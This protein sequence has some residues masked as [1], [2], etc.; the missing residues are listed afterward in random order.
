MKTHALVLAGLLL[1]SPAA[2][3]TVLTGSV[4]APDG[5]EIHYEAAGNGEPALVFVHCWSC[6]RS[7]WSGQAAH[8]AKSRRTV[9]I[10]LAGHGESGRERQRYTVE[11]FGADVKALVDALGLKRVV[12]V[13]H[14]MGGPVILE[15]AR[16]MPEKVAALVPIDTLHRV[17]QKT[18]PEERRAL[19]DPMRADFAGAARKF[20]RDFM[21]TPKSDPALADRIAQD[22]SAAPKAVAL[23]ALENL[24]DYDEAAA[25]A[26]IKAPLRLINADRWPTDLAAARKYKPDVQLAVMPGLG[27]FPMLEDPAEFNRLLERALKELLAP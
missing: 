15:A 13:G 7:Y 23:S 27:H 6:D 17:G 4:K 5:V 22:M 8:F 18:S 11:A 20:V 19:L 12:L 16:L 21:F 3:L 10:D 14:S 25:L 9:A 26:A 24:A 1:A 2:A